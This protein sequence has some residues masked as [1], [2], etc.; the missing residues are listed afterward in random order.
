VAE[1]NEAL[2]WARREVRP[3]AVIVRA[4][5]G[6]D[7][8]TVD[9]LAEHLQAAEDVVTPPAPVLLDL[10]GITYLSSAGVATLVTQCPALRRA[11]KSAG[12]GCRPTRRATAH[13]PHRCGRHRRRRT[14]RRRRYERQLRPA[15]SLALPTGGQPGRLVPAQVIHPRLAETA[16][17]TS[18]DTWSSRWPYL[19]TPT[20]PGSRGIVCG[21]GW[22]I[23]TCQASSVPMFC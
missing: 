5:G 18:V 1:T 23:R 20:T 10:T 11:E 4:G 3:D 7:A 21:A 22:R 2:F 16:Y 17:G 8:F 12:R 6:L 15:R 9:Q 19:P 14:N 13:H